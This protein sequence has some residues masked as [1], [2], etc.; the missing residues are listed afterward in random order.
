MIERSR[1]FVQ[2]LTGKLRYRYLPRWIDYVTVIVARPASKKLA[3]AGVKRVLVDNTVR[4]H[5]VTHE[6]AWV[7]TGQ[8]RWGD[9][10]ADTGYAARIPVRDDHDQSDAARSVS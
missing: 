8:A 1:S 5:G 7:S 4:A 10:E 2:D 6:T 3:A 9:H